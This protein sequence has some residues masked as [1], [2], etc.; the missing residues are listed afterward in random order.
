[1]ADINHQQGWE[2][3]NTILHRFAEELRRHYPEALLFRVYGIDFAIMTTDYQQI[4]QEEIA[5]YTSLA[6]SGI[7]PVLHHIDL[8]QQRGATIDKLERVEL[9]SR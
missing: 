1:M 7:T 3:G 6:G 4:T 8:N 9:I 2:A 5:N